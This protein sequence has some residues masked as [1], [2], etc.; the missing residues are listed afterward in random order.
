MVIRVVVLLWLFVFVETTLGDGGGMTLDAY[1]VGLFFADK[2]RRT[3]RITLGA[4]AGEPMAAPGGHTLMNQHDIL[5]I[6]LVAFVEEHVQF[7]VAIVAR[8]ADF[9]AMGADG[10][11]PGRVRIAHFD[12][13]FVAAANEMTAAGGGFGEI[14]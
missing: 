8:R 11:V 14:S 4:I 6:A 7:R 10:H 12:I 1:A 2:V 9:A 3:R 5:T 13:A